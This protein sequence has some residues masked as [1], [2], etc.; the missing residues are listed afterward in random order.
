MFNRNA[1]S[2]IGSMLLAGVLAGSGDGALAM[3]PVQVVVD[4]EGRVHER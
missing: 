4:A 3:P 1:I 2:R